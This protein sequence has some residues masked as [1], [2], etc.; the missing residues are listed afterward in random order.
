VGTPIQTPLAVAEKDAITGGFLAQ[1]LDTGD[2]DYAALKIYPRDEAPAGRPR[3]ESGAVAAD[4][5]Q[6][7]GADSL[8][9]P[10]ARELALA[11]VPQQGAVPLRNRAGRDTAVE[12]LPFHIP[13]R[14]QREQ[15]R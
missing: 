15:R 12:R 14:E 13:N 9:H 4:E 1:A 2:P 7:V 6:R 10:G 3:S 8:G 11:A 5:R